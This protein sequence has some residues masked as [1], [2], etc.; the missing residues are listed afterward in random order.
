M[1]ARKMT[2]TTGLIIGLLIGASLGILILA[3]IIGG[4][5]R[6]I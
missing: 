3:I 6:R 1:E 4:S 5:R 2:F